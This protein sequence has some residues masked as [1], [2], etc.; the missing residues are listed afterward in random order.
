MLRA[1]EWR[2]VVAFTRALIRDSEPI[3][4]VFIHSSAFIS[5]GS[6]YVTGWT[7]GGDTIFG[8]SPQNVNQKQS[9]KKSIDDFD[10]LAGCAAQVTMYLAKLNG[11][12][13]EK[14]AEYYLHAVSGPR[15]KHEGGNPAKDTAFGNM[16]P[17]LGNAVAVTPGGDVL[18]AGFTDCCVAHRANA[19]VGGVAPGAYL[20]QSDPY[21]PNQSEGVLLG[22]PPG[23]DARDFFN[24]WMQSGVVAMAGVHASG[25]YGAVVGNVAR[26]GRATTKTP[27]KGTPTNPAGPASFVAVWPLGASQAGIR[28]GTPV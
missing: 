2:A 6:V 9:V 22:M 17:G 26:G 10:S 19:T 27:L 8:V 5:Q 14:E 3:F 7:S 15:Y 24:S 21:V 28:L 4:L 12:T 20:T 1:G 16:M 11:K 25:S 18:V 23:L 13:G